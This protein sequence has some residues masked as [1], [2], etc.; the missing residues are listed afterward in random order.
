MFGHNEPFKMTVESDGKKFTAELP[1]DATLDD[2]LDA[3]VSQMIGLTWQPDTIASALAEKAESLRE[4]FTPLD[5]D[6]EG[7]NDSEN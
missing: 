7:T 3:F 2:I 6:P 5:I 1:W 4:D